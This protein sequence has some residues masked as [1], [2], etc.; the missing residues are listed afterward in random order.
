VILPSSFQPA[1]LS[2]PLIAPSAYFIERINQID[3]KI[4]KTFKVS[5]FTV[6]PQFEMFNVNNSDSIISVVTNNVLSSSYRYAN[7]I[8]QP[9]MMGVGLQ[10][11]W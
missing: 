9:R 1:T 7:S 6:S 2:V 4:Q 11:K 5:R 10:V 8:M 3:L